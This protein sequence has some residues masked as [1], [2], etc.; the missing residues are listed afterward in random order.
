M[1][2]KVGRVRIKISFLF[3]AML[4]MLF[5]V[6]KKG[7]ALI[8]VASVALHELGHIAAL[9]FFKSQPDEIVFGIFGIRIQ[10]N[11][12]ILSDFK[13]AIVVLCGPLVNVVLFAVFFLANLAF[14]GQ[15]LLMISAVNLIMGVFN[16]LPILPLDGGRI[17]FYLLGL[18]FDEKIVCGIM[19]IVCIVLLCVLALLGVLLALKTGLNFSLIATGVYLCILCIKSTRI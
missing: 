9:C 4:T 13:Q 3:F 2:F 6:D 8:T 18:F 16:L 14:E 7:L 10:Q 5:V 11:K 17:L 1:N 15:I 12:Y 19:R